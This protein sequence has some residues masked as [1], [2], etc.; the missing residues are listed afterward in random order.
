[1]PRH[2]GIV[3][4]A[5]VAASCRAGPEEGE[6]TV[7][8][9]D[10]AGVRIVENIG[11]D[12]EPP[13]TAR[14]TLRIGTVEGEEAYQFFRVVA[15]AMGPD[16]TIYVGDAGHGEVRAFDPAGRHLRTCG[17]PGEGPGEIGFPTR[18]WVAGDTLHL[19]DS[20]L[21]RVTT[22]DSGCRVLATVSGLRSS[23]VEISPLRPVA[24]GWL[25]VPN[26]YEG[27]PY[28]PGVAR[29]DTTRIVF[30]TSLSE[31]ASA[32]ATWSGGADAGPP[33]WREILAFP[34]GR[35]VG[36]ATSYAMTATAPLFEPSPR[37]TIDGAGS[38]HFSP[39]ADYAIETYS[40]DGSLLR[41]TAR[42]VPPVPVTGALIDGFRDR[43]RAFWDTASL[44]GEAPMWKESDEARS[45]FR[46]VERLPPVGRMFASDAGHLWVE[47]IDLASDPVEREWRYT[48]IPPRETLWDRFDPDGRYIGAVRLQAGFTPHV[49]GETW[50]IGVLRDELDV[51]HIARIELDG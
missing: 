49:V 31:A 51:Q 6:L 14:T 40:A 34:R 50:A 36:V 42:E 26:R 33:P 35:M 45:G 41:R 4:I 11:V 39:A 27:W 16:G 30:V 46:T 20:R 25:A 37:Y 5:L 38:V 9:T 2:A 12:P 43:T 44:D 21:G 15:M 13:A 47:R 19:L 48:P 8:T 24:G 23:N 18:I 10:S 1:M 3:V 17:R 7:V 22:F 28:E 32:Y 29:R